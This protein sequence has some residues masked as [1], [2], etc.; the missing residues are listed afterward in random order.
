MITNINDFKI[1]LENLKYEFNKNNNE[2]Q[3]YFSTDL[4]DYKVSIINNESQIKFPWLGFKAKKKEEI[5][6]F[7]DSDI[8]TNDNI[9]VVFNT[10]CNII[11]EDFNKNNNEGYLF[12]VR[13]NKKGKQRANIYKKILT[14]HNWLVIEEN[15]KFK[16]M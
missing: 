8:I 15:D 7:Y 1:I 13:Q 12:S 5:D 9:Y 4:Y 11:F 2:R 3:Y 14:K 10:L 6:F 16:I